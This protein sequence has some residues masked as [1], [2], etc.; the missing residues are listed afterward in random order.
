MKPAASPAPQRTPE[1]PRWSAPQ[2]VG[3]TLF[4]IGVVLAFWLLYQFRTAVLILFIA[5]VLGTAIRPAVLWLF[6]RGLS[7]QAGVLL[8]YFLLLAF[9]VGFAL[10]A[11]PLLIEQGTRLAGL[12][13]QYYTKTYE[14]LMHSSNRLVRGIVLQFPSRLALVMPGPASD[15]QSLDTVAQSLGYAVLGL[16]GLLVL[17]G[18]FV[19]GFYWTLESERSLRSL[20][21]L[22][23]L[24]RR[25]AAGE[26]I[27]DMEEKVGAFIRGQAIL[28]LSV[29]IAAFIA[30]LLIGL[31]YALSLGVIAGILEAVPTIGPTLGAIPA[32]LVALSIGSSKFIWVIVSVIVIQA[33]ENY[34]LA[35]RVMGHSVGVHPVVTL[36][37][38]AAFSSLFGLPG[39]LLAVPLA[40]IIQMLFHRLL[41]TIEVPDREAFANRDRISRLRYEAQSLALDVRKQSR[42]KRESDNGSGGHLEDRIEAIASDLDDQLAAADRYEAPV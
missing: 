27:A 19:L 26:V 21:R 16:R 11:L 37:A 30:D 39:A 32:L 35:P 6:K 31:P 8:I 14:I 23:P 38:L 2:V 42:V 28:M 29:G 17:L 40:A 20:L 4:V 12:L 41:T 15:D 24:Q 34:L 3:A 5:I 22:L 13:P 1:I 25:V 33:L 10:L 36:L 18:I 9:V 7:R